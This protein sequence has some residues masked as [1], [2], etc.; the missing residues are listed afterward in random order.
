MAILDGDGEDGGREEIL[1]ELP[2]PEFRLNRNTNQ[3]PRVRE[4][5]FVFC[6]LLLSSVEDGKMLVAL[7]ARLDWSQYGD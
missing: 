2:D 7:I 4:F 3:E 1:F 5:W 6:L